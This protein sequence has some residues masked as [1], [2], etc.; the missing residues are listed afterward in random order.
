MRSIDRNDNWVHWSENFWNIGILIFVD[1]TL[2]WLYLGSHQF[3]FFHVRGQCLVWY[4]SP[5]LWISSSQ[6]KN[7]W[8]YG[9]VYFS[10][11]SW[12]WQMCNHDG[13][14]AG[15]WSR[16]P[17]I[18]TASL[19]GTTMTA[20][21]NQDGPDPI[22]QNGPAFWSKRPQHFG[23]NGPWTGAILTN[24]LL[25]EIHIIGLLTKPPLTWCKW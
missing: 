14:A 16:R 10:V 21:A 7:W 25:M 11:K 9:E 23:Q 3:D 19:D 18:T 12:L 4:S 24:I 17:L 20:P 6:V 2:K 5:P 22:G 15:C 1:E 13:G 8:R